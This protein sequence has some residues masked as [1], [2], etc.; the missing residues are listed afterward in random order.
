MEK[1]VNFIYDRP[2]LK[3]V[4]TALFMIVVAAFVAKF[5]EIAKLPGALGLLAAPI[6]IGFVIFT[7]YRP[8]A[9]M[10]FSLHLSF[11]ILGIPRYVNAGP[12]GLSVDAILILLF[13]SLI[14]KRSKVDWSG[15]KNPAVIA[16]LIW[17]IYTFLMLFNP[18]ARSKVAWFYAVRGISLYAVLTIPLVFVL[19]KDKA[20]LRKVIIIWITWSTIAA[21]WGYK[22]LYIGVDSFEQ[23]WLDAGAATTHVLF[24]RLRVFSFLSDAGQFG[25]V[26]GHAS[27][28]SILL[29]IGTK[30]KMYKIILIILGIIIFWGLAISG[31]RG[32]LIIVFAGGAMYLF[33]AKNYKL[34]VLG[35]LA[36][37]LAFGFLKFT[38]IGQGNY[39]IQRMRSA[40]DPNDAS[41]Q[42][43]VENQKKL[44][45][46][47]AARPFG[48]GVG[49]GGSFGQRFTPGTF[50]AE[51]ALD[52]W[53]V[54]IWVDTGIVGLLLYL[55]M[56]F[57]FLIKGG[58]IIYN[59]RDPNLRF[60][61]VALYC[62]YFGIVVG[63]YGNQ[64]Y[65]QLPIGTMM[66]ITIA[67]LFQAKEWDSPELEN[68]EDQIYLNA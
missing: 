10:Y 59:L 64:I 43:R 24:G 55:C 48:G 29:A 61:M 14:F 36:G 38:T 4:L 20:N 34:L 44:A 54:R 57:F 47:L 22:Q 32:P 2:V 18:E 53:Y 56:L 27:L 42:V 41:L 51:T 33:M 63:S 68:E 49:S 58:I 17:F 60:K 50:L 30:N 8:A 11:V 31:S 1:V 46:Y 62:A 28:M 16:T 7:L 39:Q 26:M 3:E 21:L 13:V 15:I 12:I 9:V 19:L 25:A 67:F 52:S 6:G 45:A 40:L 37:A 23:R 5:V 65:G 66:Y 35:A